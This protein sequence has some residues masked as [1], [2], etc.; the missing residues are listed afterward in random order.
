[1]CLV[2][3]CVFDE[4]FLVVELLDCGVMVCFL[5]DFFIGEDWEEFSATSVGVLG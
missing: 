2:L 5:G 3:D 1:M 4:L